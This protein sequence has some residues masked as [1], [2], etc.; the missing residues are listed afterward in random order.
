MHALLEE[1]LAALLAQNYS[2]DTVVTRRAAIGYFIDWCRERSL[3]DPLEITRPILERY[4][5]WLFQYRKHN[6]DPLTFRTQAMRLRAIK[7]WF[8]WLA[9]QN[10]LLHNP[11]S[12]LLLPRFEMRLPKYVLSAE[13]AERVLQQPD[14]TTPAGLRDRAILET[15]YSTGM[16]RMEVARMKLHDIDAGR[17][18]VM[19]R[20]GK[21]KKDRLI[22]I[23]E[24]ALAW[25]AKYLEQARPLLVKGNDDGTVFVNDL[26][27]PFE[28]TYVTL[29]V[30]R[31]IERAKIGKSGGCHLFRHSVATLMLENGAD[32]RVVQELLGHAKITTTEMYTHVSINLLKQVYASTHP[33]ARLEKKS[34]RQAEEHAELMARLAAERDEE[35]RE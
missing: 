21:G 25:I 14:V 8:R 27:E 26:G 11:A 22:P 35:E 9:R 17:G 15:F 24:R 19:V 3:E 10:Y 23:G 7:G 1:H 29:L 6:G 5:R 32:V 34:A 18:T 31:Y 16:R 2:E 20:M 13:E 28:R 4:Q 30:R 33:G 12:E